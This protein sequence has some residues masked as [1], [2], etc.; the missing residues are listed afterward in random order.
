MASPTT[1]ENA[2]E[3]TGVNNMPELHI[4]MAQPTDYPAI[5]AMGETAD[6]GTLEGFEDTLIAEIF[7]PTRG[8]NAHKGTKAK[9]A[10]D[11]AS[12]GLG[13]SLAESALEGAP[14]LAG[15][16]RIRIYSGVAHVNPIVVAETL[17]GMHIGERLMHVARERYGEL[18]FVAR[19]YAVGFY[20]KL[21]C[22][23]CTWEDI[24]PE[25]AGDCDGCTALES[26]KPF[27]MRFPVA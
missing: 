9:G 10:E 22:T 15:F 14:M 19:G 1:A 4:R 3:L 5:I 27:P 16:C 13:E 21:G 6:M 8:A 25:V 7:Q 2:P 23:P 18:R 17:R 20:E 12:A 11:A 26:C 24:A